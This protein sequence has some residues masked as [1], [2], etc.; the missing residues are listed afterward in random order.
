MRRWSIPLRPIAI[1]LTLGFALLAGLVLATGCV[2]D[3]QSRP[4]VVGPGSAPPNTPRTWTLQIDVTTADGVALEGAAVRV[5]RDNPA[6]N[7]ATGVTDG[8]GHH[9]WLSLP[10][11]GYSACASKLPEY[12]EVCV[13]VNLVESRDG[14]NPA[15]I[16]L[17]RTTPAVVA[18][19][20]QVRAERHVFVDDD[21]PFL[22]LGTSLFWGLWGELHDAERV[23][24]NL[25]AARDAGFDYVRVL[26][27]VGPDGWSDRTVR[28]TDAGWQAGI[29]SFTERAAHNGLRVQWTIFGTP[30]ALSESQRAETVSRFLTAIDGVHH[31][32]AIVEL[33]NEGFALGP[34]PAEAKRLV[35][36]IANR[37]PGLVATTA[38]KD[39]T[40]T[41]QRR[42][43]EGSRATLTTLHLARG[44]GSDGLYRPIRQVWR[45][46]AH[47][48]PGVPHA[49]SNNEPIGPQSSVAADDDVT[50]IVGGAAVSWLAGLGA[51]V[52]HT[53]A[54]IRGGGAEDLARGRPA[55]LWES[56][57]WAPIAQGLRQVRALLP[58][59]LSNWTRHNWNWASNPFDIRGL[60][61]A[62]TRHSVMSVYTAER[63]GVAWSVPIWVR[64]DKPAV[65]YAPK[66]GTWRFEVYDPA[67]GNRIAE[68]A[69][70]PGTPWALPRS[71]SVQLVKAVRQ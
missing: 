51:Y 18:R 3:T 5:Y 30:K 7:T 55:N 54:G 15:R 28:V 50:R 10:Q 23:D 12:P 20:G 48:C 64:S 40:C 4:V 19:R 63:H 11:A 57:N 16:V 71:P 43:Y 67:T 13:G 29:R 6:V 38:P 9:H 47:T 60:D 1:T 62:G 46:G 27:Q 58:A 37:F 22:A 65:T 56:P 25:K 21:G 8:A 33:S 26:T 45:E 14:S 17:T 61:F 34:E 2:W 52:A 66:S 42:W 31:A 59:D 41:E 53:G 24:A 36:I 32:V 35:A 44:P 69:T 39:D 49:Y 70:S 68:G